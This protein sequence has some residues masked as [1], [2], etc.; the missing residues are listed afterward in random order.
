MEYEEED[1][2]GVVKVLKRQIKQKDNK[3]F[4]ELKAV[5]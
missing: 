1:W 4:D 3:Q 2:D 5:E